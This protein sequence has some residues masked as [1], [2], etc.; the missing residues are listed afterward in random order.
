MAMSATKRGNFALRANLKMSEIR[1][2]GATAHVVVHV[3]DTDNTN[4]LVGD[5]VRQAAAAHILQFRSIRCIVAHV[6]RTLGGID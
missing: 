3:G 2:V 5:A 1:N 6:D 4:V